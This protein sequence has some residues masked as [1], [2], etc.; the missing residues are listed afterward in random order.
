MVNLVQSL[1][2]GDVSYTI[3]DSNTIP[4]LTAGQKS[5]LLASGT[6]LDKAVVDG[7]VF[8]TDAG[9][10]ERFNKTIIGSTI[11]WTY[12]QNTR[13]SGSGITYGKGVYVVVGPKGID[14]STNGTNWSP[15]NMTVNLQ[16]YGWSFLAYGKGVFICVTDGKGTVEYSEDGINWESF[17]MPAAKGWTNVA[18]A[19]DRFIAVA[20]GSNIVAYSFNGKDWLSSPLGS[21]YTLM[22]IAYGNGTYVA[23]GDTYAFYSINGVNW[24]RVNASL[25]SGQQCT[26]VAYGNGR[27]VAVIANDYN[28]DIMTST[29]GIS[30]TIQNGAMPFSA[31]WFSIIFTGEVFVAVGGSGSDAPGAYSY[32]GVNWMGAAM[33]LIGDWVALTNAEG[34][35]VAVKTNGE[36]AIGDIDITYQYSTTPLSYTAA[37]VDAM[38]AQ[39]TIT[40]D[41]VDVSTGTLVL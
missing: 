15:A 13:S 41:K 18:Y 8:E 12:S 34:N 38:V 27:F 26:S 28:S 24:N 9:K 1:K 3:K 33:P 31:Y 29:D 32:D 21:T 16:N 36:V 14:Y 2:F 5:V 35:A 11:N 20:R 37:E 39:A 30:W 19:N 7:K 6:Y 23:V 25:P 17:N 10:F 22:G 4:G 40:E